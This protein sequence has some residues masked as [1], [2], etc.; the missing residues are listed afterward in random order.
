MIGQVFLVTLV[1][2]LMSLYGLERR[3]TVNVTV[4]ADHDGTP[5]ARVQVE[6]DDEDGSELEE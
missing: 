6:I 2:R 4:D 5:D 3:Q 1:A